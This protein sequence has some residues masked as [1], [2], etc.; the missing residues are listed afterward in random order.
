MFIWKSLGAQGII[1]RGK[2]TYL[3]NLFLAML[4]LQTEF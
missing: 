2:T 1:S 3:Y 4:P